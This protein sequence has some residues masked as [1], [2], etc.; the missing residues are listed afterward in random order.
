MTEINTSNFLTKYLAETSY[1]YRIRCKIHFVILIGM[2]R[3]F[4][5]NLTNNE[6][7]HQFLREVHRL[8]RN[9]NA[10]VSKFQENNVGYIK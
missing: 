10:L 1:L 3:E 2:P 6:I 9:T 8:L 5:G 4:S 7:S